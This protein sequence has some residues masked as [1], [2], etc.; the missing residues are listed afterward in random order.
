ME[1][2]KIDLFVMSN[3]DKFSPQQWAMVKEKLQTIP[4]NK[5]TEVLST[6]FRSPMNV[7]LL[8]IFLGGWGIDRFILGETGLG[9]LKLLTG[10]GCGIWSIID[11]FTA[12]KRTQNYNFNKFNESLMF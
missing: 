1:Q 5:E 10:G 12:Q 9:I 11:W 8:S 2:N 6:D 4:A 3:R 7:L